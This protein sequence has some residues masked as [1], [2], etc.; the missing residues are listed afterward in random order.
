MARTVT[1]AVMKGERADAFFV[2]IIVV[3]D[4]SCPQYDKVEIIVDIEPRAIWI[5][6]LHCM[7]SAN[8]VGQF[9]RSRNC[10]NLTNATVDM[11]KH[12]IWRAMEYRDFENLK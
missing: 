8:R 6:P 1:P 2:L 11:G 3:N 5:D 7:S 4:A 10:A 9:I 12:T